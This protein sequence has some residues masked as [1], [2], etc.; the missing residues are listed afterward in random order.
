MHAFL[1]TSRASYDAARNART[2]EGTKAKGGKKDSRMRE[3]GPGEKEGERKA[4]IDPAECIIAA[5]KAP[6]TRV[7]GE[8]PLCVQP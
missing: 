2:S 4:E 5:L 3:G 8:R 1:F 6:R 7:S